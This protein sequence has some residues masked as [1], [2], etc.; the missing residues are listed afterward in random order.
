MNRDHSHL[1]DLYISTMIKPLIKAE[2]SILVTAI[3]VA[4]AHTTALYSCTYG[5]GCQMKG[6]KL[7]V[8]CLRE[9]YNMLPLH[10]EGLC[11]E[12]PNTVVM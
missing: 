10:I 3:Q 8:W 7:P 9:A 5:K 12:N 6:D 1:D 2:M 4:V 11:R